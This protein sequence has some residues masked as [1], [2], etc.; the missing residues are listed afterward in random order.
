M[1]NEIAPSFS[2]PPILH[3]QTLIYILQTRTPRQAN[4]DL[5]LREQTLQHMLHTLLAFMC[6]T[7]ENRAPELD[8]IC[9]ESKG[10]E[11]VDPVS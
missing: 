2:L 8:K 11:T 3:K 10:F 9:A 7:P 5:K 4:C 6:Q 1:L